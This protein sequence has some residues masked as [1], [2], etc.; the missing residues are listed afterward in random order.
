MAAPQDEDVVAE[1]E[2]P[3]Y[4]VRPSDNVYSFFMFIGPTE[5]KKKNTDKL[6]WDIVMAYV[7]VVLNFF[8][9]TILVWLVFES[10]VV[11]N[12]DWQNGILKLSSGAM[13]GLFEEAPSQC[14]E[15]GALCFVDHSGVYTCSPPS[16]QLIGR[17]DELDTNKDGIW[18]WDE[19]KD[20]QKN[21]QCKYVVDPQ[22][23]FLVLVE[24]LKLRENLIWVHPE[25]KAGKMIHRSYFDYIQGDIVIC[26]YRSEDMCP[27]LLERGFFEAPLKHGTAPRVGTEIESALRYCRGLLSG[28]GICETLLPSTYATWKVQSEAECGSPSYSK[29]TYTNPGNGVIKSLLEVD[30]GAPQEYSLAQEAPF[31]IFKGIILYIWLL[32]MFCEFKETWKIITVVA[33]YPSAEDFGDDAVLMEQD[34]S[35]PED[36]RYRIQGLTYNHRRLMGVLSIFRVGITTALM[37]VGMSY[38]IRTNGYVD[39]LMNGV[40][41]LF[42]AD[43]SNILYSQVLR[44]EI[45]DQTNDIKAMKVPMYGIEWLNRRPALLDIVCQC[46]LIA[47]VYAVMTWNLNQVTLPIYNALTCTCTS[48]GDEC[49]EAQHFN[50]PWWDNYWMKVVPG[51]F[52]EVDAL[53]ATVPGAAMLFNAA[54]S[55]LEQPL[56]TKY[57]QQLESRIE[58]I[59]RDNMEL[60]N[61]VQKLEREVDSPR[62]KTQFTIATKPSAAESVYEKHLA[63]IKSANSTQPMKKNGSSLIQKRKAVNKIKGFDKAQ[64]LSRLHSL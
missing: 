31:R 64:K 53:K 25:V 21:L 39:L 37:F 43:V 35:D 42:V 5:S 56:A 54:S 16:V 48:S 24:M 59:A 20:N 13:G 9:Q 30:Y 44:A 7:L 60:Q 62:P 41:L 12:L 47:L 45:Q 63:P 18:T 23:V 50:K 17:W 14:N 57:H 10:V 3:C 49:F 8:M 40:T 29:F 26:G 22:E 11:D 32:L 55:V 52:K 33:R 2:P 58:K 36:V 28:G 15:G 1:S 6:T 46:C 4:L 61:M 34:P 19:M 51:V 27:N 38:I